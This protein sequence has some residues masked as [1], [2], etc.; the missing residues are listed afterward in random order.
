MLQT[1]DAAD[2]IFQNLIEPNIS[3]PKTKVLTI[4]GRHWRVKHAK[5]ETLQE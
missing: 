5:A 4:Y 1:P 3:A 2:S